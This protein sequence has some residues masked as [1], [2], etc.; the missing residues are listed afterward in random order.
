MDLTPQDA[1]YWQYSRHPA[2]GYFDHPPAHAYTAIITTAIFGDNAF[3]I[4]F[5][6]WLYG[7][8]LLLIIWALTKRIWNE[9]TGFWALLAAGTA[10]LFSIGSSVLTPDPPLLFFWGVA[11]YSAYRALSESKPAWWVL[12]GLTAGLAMLSKYTAVFL[13]FGLVGSLFFTRKGRRQLLTPWPYIGLVASIAAFSPQII[14]NARNDWVSFT[15]QST[16]R[17]GEITKWRLD[18]FAGM[19]GSQI[20]VVSPLLFGGVVWAS[21][22]S[23][24]KGIFRRKKKLFFLALF[25]VPVLTFFTI[26][27]LR[28]W[29]KMNWLAPAYVTAAITF[30]G[31]T[32]GENRLRKFY[33]AAIA[34]AAVETILLYLIVLFPLVPLQGEAVYWEGWTELSE[35][36]QEERS[37]MG[38]NPF[39]AGWGYKVPSELAF[40]LPDRPETHS[41][42]ILGRH[43]LN[44]TYWT[45]TESL[46]GRDCIFIADEREPFRE[47]ELLSGHFERVEKVGEIKPKRGDLEVTTFKIWR[48]FGYLGS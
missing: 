28:Y 2:A 10:P 19:I 22:S 23:A 42:E 47:I 20:A 17:A 7:V 14:W 25:S 38:S 6:P 41:N 37:S 46:I 8:G 1:Y 44:Y 40:Y 9:K 34:V 27:A 48:C 15:Y 13:F 11:V 12:A 35:R 36:V 3:G 16:R 21:Y 4:R 29:V 30:A 18:L 26:I 39:I 24:I 45:D 32:I 5:G 43:G 33:K 31:M